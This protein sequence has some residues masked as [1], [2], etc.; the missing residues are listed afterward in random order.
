MR[1][2]DVASDLFAERTAGFETA[3]PHRGQ[4]EFVDDCRDALNLRAV[5]V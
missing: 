3:V 5:G 2:G 4:S 1:V